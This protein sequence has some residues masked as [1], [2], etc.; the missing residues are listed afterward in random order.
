DE[1]GIPIFHGIEANIDA[2]GG[3]STDDETLAA[4]DLVVASPHAALGQ[5]R[6]AATERLVNAVEHPH[7]DVLG[8]P[9]GRLINERS[10]L[11]PDVEAI[12]TA[13][14]AAGT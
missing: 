4:L 7:V 3:I 1:V 5:D 9:T 14:S 2:E 13:A 6:E 12:A 11:D 8:H 10:G